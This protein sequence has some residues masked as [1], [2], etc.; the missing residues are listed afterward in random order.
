MKITLVKQMNNTFKIAYNSDYEEAKK[1]KTGEEYQCT[2]VRPRNYKFHKLFFALLQMVYENQEV[3]NNIDFMREELTKASGYYV[4]FF[5]HKGIECFR[6]KSIS[7]SSMDNDEFKV[8][9]D[10]FLDTVILVNGF[11][12]ETILENLEDF[13]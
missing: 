10:K 11:D 8:F 4:S 6:A 7:F 3:Y 12:K 1:L 13:M 9:F 5:N 2:I